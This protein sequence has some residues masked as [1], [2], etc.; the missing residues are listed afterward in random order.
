MRI[1]HRF[2]DSGLQVVGNREIRGIAATSDLQEDGFALDMAGA[3]V[4]R[5]KDGKGPLID[6]HV[7]PNILGVVT[8]LSKTATTMPFRARL[9][10]EGVSD[11]AD[12]RYREIRDG[13]ANYFSI[14]FI[15]DESVALDPRKPYGPCRAT[16]WT[17]Y[18]ISLA[19]IPVDPKAVVTA[20]SRRAI[21]GM[22][23]A[24]NACDRALDQHRAGGRHHV[25]MNDALERLAEH[26]AHAGTAMRAYRAAIESKDPETAIECQ[27]RCNRAIEGMGRELRAIGERHADAS[28]AHSALTR[29]MREV[30]KAL[31]GAAIQNSDGVD[32]DQG[33]RSRRDDFNRRQ[34]RLRVLQLSP[35]AECDDDFRQRA[36]RV[37]ELGAP[38][39]DY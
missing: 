8:D 25:A 9:S 22:Q 14:G 17:L 16:K 20:R 1:I 23:A 29:A 3:N 38:A 2:V 35:A 26:R 7:T 10:S 39:H 37:L 15:V 4:D 34:R 12:Q 27:A 18:E 13:V 32:D 33:S 24:L 31:G 11:L 6:N 28:D 21:G 5:F 36:A 19:S 30:D